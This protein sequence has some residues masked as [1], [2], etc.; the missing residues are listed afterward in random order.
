MTI[1]EKRS[2]LRDVAE[3]FESLVRSFFGDGLN[4]NI[5][6]F[7]DGDLHIQVIDWKDQTF[8]STD[9]CY[10]AERYRFDGRWTDDMS[11]R[12]NEDLKESGQYYE[13]RDWFADS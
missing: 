11:D 13:R 4:A 1:E 10:I 2:A 6:L 9:H 12:K 7:A 8:A 3:E 5:T